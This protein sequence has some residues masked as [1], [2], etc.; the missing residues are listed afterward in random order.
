MGFFEGR[1]KSF[2]QWHKDSEE[3]TWKFW[4]ALAIILPPSLL[5]IV[6][7]FQWMW[8]TSVAEA[9]KLAVGKSVL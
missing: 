8:R 4:L 2:K 9:V 6:E 7:P 3:M 5:I 1:L